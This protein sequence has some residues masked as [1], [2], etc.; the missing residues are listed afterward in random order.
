M[1]LYHKQN[2]RSI[3][4]GRAALYSGTK[5]NSAL[6][7]SPEFAAALCRWWRRPVTDHF[8]VMRGVDWLGEMG[9]GAVMARIA[10]GDVGVGRKGFIFAEK[11]STT[12]R[13]VLMF[14]NQQV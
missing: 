9:A 10:M 7:R 11:N 13:V 3:D 14:A 12:E 1:V 8:H 6:T 5:E 4:D 2:L